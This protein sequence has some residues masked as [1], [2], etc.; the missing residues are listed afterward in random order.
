MDFKEKMNEVLKKR[1]FELDSEFKKIC[2]KIYDIYDSC[3][4]VSN[5]K[6]FCNKE[7]RTLEMV[8]LNRGVATIKKEEWELVYDTYFTKTNLGIPFYEALKKEVI[9]KLGIY[10]EFEYS[11]NEEIPIVTALNVSI[12]NLITKE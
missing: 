1:K 12:A 2:M 7:T 9:E 8:T 11:E 4:G 3:A 6:I 10:A 5:I